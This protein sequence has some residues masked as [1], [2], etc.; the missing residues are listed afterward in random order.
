MILDLRYL[1]LQ[2]FKFDGTSTLVRKPTIR[3]MILDL[4]YLHLQNFKFDGTNTLVLKP[5]IHRKN[6]KKLDYLA[7]SALLRKTID[8]YSKDNTKLLS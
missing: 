8:I 4:R 3:R 6:I 5:T 1:H 2:N 7:E